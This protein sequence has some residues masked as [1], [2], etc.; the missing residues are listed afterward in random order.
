M[1]KTWKRE[2]ILIG[3]ILI[4]ALIFYIFNQAAAKKPAV[5]VE[6]SVDG[7]VVETLDLNQDADLVI[8]GY[9]GGTNHLIIRSGEAYVEEAS[10]PDKV[11]VSQGKIRHTGQVIVCLPN[12]MI[13]TVAGE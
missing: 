9:K 2:V 13:V 11:C 5:K 8:E 10:C 6:V 1:K 3:G 12:K 7:K 4:F